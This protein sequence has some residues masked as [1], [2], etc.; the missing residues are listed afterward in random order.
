M[1]KIGLLTYDIPHLKTYQILDGLIKKNYEVVLLKTKFF[2]KYKKTLHSHRPN[3]LNFKKKIKLSKKKIE[4][5]QFSNKKSIHDLKYVLIG[6]S[7]IIEKKKIIKNKIINCHSGLIPQTRGLDSIKWS[8]Y[9]TNLVGNT[10]HYI[11]EKIDKGKLI[12]QEITKLNKDCSLKKFYKNHYDN[13]IKMLINF[14][15]FI[16]NGSVF[17]LESNLA[18]KR[19]PKKLE[20]KINEKFLIYKKKYKNLK[21]KLKQN[22][23]VHQTSI[24]DKNVTIGDDTKIWHWCHI[25]RNAKIGKNCVLGQNCYIG[26]NVSIGNNVHIQN[27]VS[28]FSGVEI[29]DNVFIGPSVVFTNVKLPSALIKQKYLKTIVY[30]CAV[31]GANSTIICGN[32]IGKNSFVGAGSVVTKDVKKGTVVIGVPAKILKK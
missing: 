1:T 30:D 11:D 21:N 2:K 17:N 8:I 4:I 5:R 14:E 26:E 24:L 16:N 15:K 29:K 27:N 12:H 19:F 25:S 7:G 18:T 9:N 23:F 22:Y 3:Q 31:V 13:E 6:G 10:L 20:R 32:N 28:V